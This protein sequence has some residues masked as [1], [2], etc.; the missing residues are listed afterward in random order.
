MAALIELRGTSAGRAFGISLAFVALVTA[1]HVINALVIE[2]TLLNFSEDWNVP[3]F[4]SGVLFAGAAV[5]AW[6]AARATRSRASGSGFWVFVAVLA[7]AAGIESV[8]DL[9]TRIEE[10]GSLEDIVFVL[11]P[12][13]GIV[14]IIA[15]WGQIRRLE[16]PSPLLLISAAGLIV[17]SQVVGA[18][19]STVD[20]TG[21]ARDLLIL[22]EEVGEM[23]S[24]CLVILAGAG[25]AVREGRRSPSA[26]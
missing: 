16:A 1:L 23:L 5:A 24:P 20:V 26:A 3:T 25:V 21:N 11:T 22:V 8:A 2:G 18:F 7:A 17:L 12:V 15:L 6:R 9:H 4:A 10:A 19:I 14:A 13:L